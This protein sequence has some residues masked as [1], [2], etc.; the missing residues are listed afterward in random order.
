MRGAGAW[1]MLGVDSCGFWGRIV[2]LELGLRVR[3]WLRVALL[4]ATLAVF[5]SAAHAQVTVT[6]NKRE[7]VVSG[8]TASALVRSMNSNP[9][10]GDHGSAY[11]SIHP[12]YNLSV[13]TKERGGMCKAD[14]SIRLRLDLTLPKAASPAKM[15]SRTRSAWNGFANYARSHEAWHQSS[16]T[17]CARSFVGWAERMSDKQCISLQSDIRT[18]FSTMK[19][20]CEAR[21]LDYD[22]GQRSV[23]ARMALF[24][25][26]RMGR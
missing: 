24:S 17:G 3:V 25:M 16:Y 19:R 20:D 9:I 10:H 12:N 26:A 2:S 6:V 1:A 5:C 15:S 18:A 23:V 22:R 8:T 4:G 7:H 11:A 13:R 14:V 21:Q